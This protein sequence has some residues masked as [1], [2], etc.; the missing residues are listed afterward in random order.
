MLKQVPCK[1]WIASGFRILSLQQ[2]RIGDNCYVA[3]T[4]DETFE[5]GFEVNRFKSQ[6]RELKCQC[7]ENNFGVNSN[8]F[9]SIIILI[10]AIVFLA[11]TKTGKKGHVHM[12]GAC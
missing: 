1:E 2:H 11:K 4:E 8:S 9:V 10:S 3:I 5:N 12:H 7:L 6:N